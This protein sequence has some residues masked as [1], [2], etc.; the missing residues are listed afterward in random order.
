MHDNIALSNHQSK[1][2][3][4]LVTRG[5]PCRPLRGKVA[6]KVHQV[7]LPSATSASPILSSGCSKGFISTALYQLHPHTAQ[8]K[9]AYTALS[10]CCTFG[11]I[12]RTFLTRQSNPRQCSTPA[13]P[14]AH[15][16]PHFWPHTNKDKFPSQKGN[17]CPKLKLLINSM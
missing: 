3:A 14:H 7:V 8:I 16:I 4:Q 12:S 2:V 6:L 5:D 11:R 10:S 9:V 1:S 13:V 15:H 17:H